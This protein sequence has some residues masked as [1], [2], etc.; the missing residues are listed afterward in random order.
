[1]KIED[2][3]SLRETFQR[4]QEISSIN[5]KLETELEKKIEENAKPEFLLE[6][7]RQNAIQKNNIPEKTPTELPHLSERRNIFSSS[8]ENKPK[9][10]EKN[11]HSKKEQFSLETYI[12]RES[13]KK[14]LDPD[15]VRAII[16]TESNFNPRAESKKGA[17]GLMQ[18]MPSTADALGVEDPFNPVQ[19]VKG[20]TDY[21]RDM[22]K[23]FKNK[24]LAIAA[25]N[26]GPGAVKKFGGIPPYSETQNYV[27][28]V[29]ED[30]ENYKDE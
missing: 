11:P 27:K 18:L 14:G 13:R 12:Q 7:E 4:M 6:L 1:M 21:L 3:S 25:Y 24:D 5:Q 26:A 20:G 8:T 2:I 9:D 23:I 10:S 28:K 22:L 30:L 29:N 19:N 16:K 15:L 17:M